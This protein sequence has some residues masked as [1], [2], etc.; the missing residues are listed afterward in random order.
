MDRKEKPPVIVLSSMHHDDE[1]EDNDVRKM[2][3]KIVDNNNTKARVDVV[4]KN[5]GNYSTK[6]KTRR[7]PLQVFY[8]ILDIIALNAFNIN[9]LNFP[10]WKSSSHRKGCTVPFTK[11]LGMHW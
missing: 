11:T 8:T 9:T 6:I 3:I 4:D 7:W 2:P 10:D 5:V 1:I